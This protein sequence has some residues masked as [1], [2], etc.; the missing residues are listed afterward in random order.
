VEGD[1]VQHQQQRLSNP[2]PTSYLAGSEPSTLVGPLM[3][4]EWGALTP[5]SLPS[6]KNREI[7]RHGQD[8]WGDGHGQAAHQQAGPVADRALSGCRRDQPC[9][10]AWISAILWAWASASGWPIS[11][12]WATQMDM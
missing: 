4:P 2:G 7:A 9:E 5:S 1:R 10:R 11:R 6:P 12:P 8:R 3:V